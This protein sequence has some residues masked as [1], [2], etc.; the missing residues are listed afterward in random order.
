VDARGLRDY[1]PAKGG[2]VLAQDKARRA[3]DEQP[4]VAVEVVGVAEKVLEQRLARIGGTWSRGRSGWSE[5]GRGMTR[6]AA[7]SAPKRSSL[8]RR[9][10]RSPM[11]G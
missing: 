11:G 2:D 1:E 4:R 3:L 10:P 7:I 9:R 8:G 6:V 5:D